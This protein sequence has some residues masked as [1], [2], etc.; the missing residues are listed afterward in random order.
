MTEE[1]EL[2]SNARFTSPWVLTVW[3]TLK[4]KGIPFADRTVDLKR[5]DHRAGSYPRDTITAKVPALRHGDFWLA[6]SLAIVD[7]LES[8]FPPPRHPSVLPADRRR[9]A[10]DFQI[11][12]WIR[13]DLF[14]LRECMPFEGLFYDLP[15]PTVTPKAFEQAAKLLA[16]SSAVLAERIPTSP[17]AADFDLTFM[18]RRLVRYRHDLSRHAELV[19]YCNEIWA[20]PSVQSYVAVERPPA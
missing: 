5:G 20:R 15:P 9:R 12:S 19:G 13:S 8:V 3:V 6:E 14:E 1:I 7:Y 10:R 18:L 11:M 2:W 17:T 4:E 16:V